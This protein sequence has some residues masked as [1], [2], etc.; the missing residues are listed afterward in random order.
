MR[1]LE[2]Q[3]EWDDV[4]VRV[5]GPDARLLSASANSSDCRVYRTPSA[6]YKMRRVTPASCRMRLNWLE[7][8]FLLLQRLTSIPAIPTARTYQ[9]FEDWEFIEMDP[10]P[11]LRGYDPTFGRPKET[12][13]DF[14]AVIRL[15]LRINRL[16]CSHGDLRAAN[17]GRNVEDGLSAF[18][19]DQAQRAHPIRCMLRDFCGLAAGTSRGKVSLLDRARDV[20]GIGGFLRAIGAAGRVAVSAVAALYRGP[21][22]TRGPAISTLTKRATLQ[23]DPA[24][25]SLARAWELA[26]GSQASSPGLQLAYY[27][28]DVGGINFPGERPWVLR[29]NSLRTNVDFKGKRF[30]ELGCNVG[31]LSIHARLHG[32]A[33]SVAVDVDPDILKAAANAA[34][35]FG[36]E[37]QFR[38]LDLNSIDQSDLDPNQFDIVS[39]LSVM[40]WVKHKERA[41]SFL[42]RFRELLYEGHE[43]EEE[44]ETLLRKAG[45]TQV[46]RLG[47]TERNRQIFLAQR[48][49]RQP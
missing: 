31:L 17:V 19:F 37:V 41:W 35:G 15:T 12:L 42:S 4:V 30:L 47:V 8:E 21:V 26:A 7:D 43:P 29:W 49:E 40:H 36:T 22:H 13:R 48:T 34:S 45:F 6:V 14:L 46:I 39:A 28:L 25:V 3:K 16:G 27:S 33:K 2:E 38:Q 20:R 9:R 1:Y 23:N 10:L 5:A 11:Q 44:A 18:D 24:L 32:A